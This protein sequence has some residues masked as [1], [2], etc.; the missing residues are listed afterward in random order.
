VCD[1]M[2]QWRKASIRGVMPEFGVRL[3]AAAEAAA[4]APFRAESAARVMP[5]M[6]L[7]CTTTSRK[8]T[9]TSRAT[10]ACNRS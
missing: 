9:R 6:S 10:F 4:A 7:T 1:V 8:L 3:G 5:P 2:P